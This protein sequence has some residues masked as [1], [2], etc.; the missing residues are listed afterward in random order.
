FWKQ[1]RIYIIIMKVS[2]EADNKD[3]HEFDV[4]FL[5]YAKEKLYSAADDGKIKVWT[6]DL[7]LLG[8]VQAHP[9][10]VFSLAASEDTLYSS[11]NDG[12]VKAWS[13]DDLKEKKTLLNEPN[14]EFWRVAWN[15]GYL[16]VGDDQGNI[17]VYNNEEYYG[18]MNIAEPV[19]DMAV[20]GHILFTANLD[21][22]VTDVKL[23]GKNLQSINRINICGKAPITLA[24]NTLCFTNREGRDII[25][26]EKDDDKKWKEL[27]QLKGAHELIINTLAGGFRDGKVHLFSG[28]WDKN[29]KAWIIQNN[30]IENKGSCD[31]GFTVN[32]LV[33][34][35][36]GIVYAAGENGNMVQIDAK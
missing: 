6:P 36:D 23:Q 2:V 4:N 31:V 17:R 11:S 8:E 3:K 34:G 24:G 22:I 30:K 35:D 29:V 14:F 33:L 21:I 13:L 27:A 18:I 26:H 16:Y 15:N 19:K 32:A 7:K 20:D 25:V 5:L 9:C 1:E 28:G 12:T 10:S